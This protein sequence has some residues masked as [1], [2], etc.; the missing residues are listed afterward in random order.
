MEELRTY[1]EMR[2]EAMLA[3]SR[4]HKDS[5]AFDLACIPKDTRIQL[6]K[7]EEYI[8]FTKKE[9]AELY[10]KQLQILKEVIDG[11]HSSPDPTKGNATEMLKALEMR[12][13]LLFA[14][15]NIE[16]DESNA[17][18]IVMLKMGKEEFD[19][20]ETIE[21]SLPNSNNENN[22]NSLEDNS[23]ELPPEV[24][25]K[26]KEK[27]TRREKEQKEKLKEKKS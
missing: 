15:L 12:N 1:E 7:D 24:K 18:N 23:L 6:L 13:K 27:E 25:A 8:A 16:A 5:L 26:L 3:F 14:D 21:V 11:E 10:A 22:N 19:S 17:L 9:K 2:Q 4:I 20:M